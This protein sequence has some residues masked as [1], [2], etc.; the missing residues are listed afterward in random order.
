MGVYPK[1]VRSKGVHP[2][3]QTRSIRAYAQWA[4][5]LYNKLD[6]SGHMLKGRL[7]KGRNGR[8]TKGRT[9]KGRTSYKT[10]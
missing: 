2:I 9:L 5:V 8:I 10:N 1:G 3:Q 7:P 4:F 6:Q